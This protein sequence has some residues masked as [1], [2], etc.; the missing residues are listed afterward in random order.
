MKVLV[1]GATGL[2][3]SNL[4]R[5]LLDRGHQIKVFLQPGSSTKTIDNLP[6]EIVE[7]D[8]LSFED[9]LAAAKNTEA[10]FH[11]A[12]DTSVWPAR[13]PNTVKV[14]VD[15]TRNA[16][17]VA[18]AVKVKRFIHVGTANSF[19][20]GNSQN[21]GRENTPYICHKYGLDYMDSKQQAQQL[22]Q[23]AIQKGLPAIIV[24]PTF[25]IGPYDSKP[26][27]GQMIL[28]VHSGVVKGFTEGGKNYICVKDAAT[29]IANAL[30]KGRIGECYILGHENLSYKEAFSKIAKEIN[31]TP[32]KLKLPKWTVV[33]AGL[34]NSII[35]RFTHKNPGITYPL[36]R[37]A[38]E[39]HYYSSA[40][41]VKELDLPQTPIEEGIR[42]SF[43]WLKTN[44]YLSY[45]N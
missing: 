7:G 27:S 22:V 19:S 3:G 33:T 2:L 11:L 14:N 42:Q 16:I 20:Y 5:I 38:C 10:L 29:G 15:G 45:E 9:F 34:V 37:I 36:A 32:P 43:E 30:N 13:N 4:L 28:A 24:N 23:E 18:I 8:I 6:I 1:T 25:M 17:H 41:A 44:K 40:K 39:E 26:S 35:S 31:M 21:P 12:A